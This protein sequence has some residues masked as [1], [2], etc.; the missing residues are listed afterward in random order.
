MRFHI[1]VLCFLCCLPVID[2][3]KSYSSPIVVIESNN[4][5]LGTIVQ[6]DQVKKII[7]IKNIGDS[8]LKLE[9]ISTS[10][11]CTVVNIESKIISPGKSVEMTIIFDS[12]RFTGDV[13]KHIYITTNDPLHLNNEISFYGK[14]IQEIVVTPSKIDFGKIIKNGSKSYSIDIA[15]YGETPLSVKNVDLLLQSTNV[16]PQTF[17]VPPH[18]SKT[19]KIVT[20]PPT[21]MTRLSGYVIFY[22]DSVRMPEL[23][24]PVYGTIE[25]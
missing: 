5:D 9:K 25:Q 3:V 14:I 2:P 20:T 12:S 18:G 16:T 8:N 1:L 10:C 23:R 17:V 11:G 21:G 13:N 4:I 15:N 24:V 7:K 19:V 22:T 6:G